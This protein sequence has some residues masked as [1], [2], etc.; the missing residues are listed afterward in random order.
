LHFR[1]GHEGTLPCSRRRFF[2]VNDPGNALLL[3]TTD[4]MSCNN[5]H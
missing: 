3:L 1:A 5:R 4:V 2:L